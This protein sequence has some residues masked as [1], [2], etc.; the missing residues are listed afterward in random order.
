MLYYNVLRDNPGNKRYED[1]ETTHYK[2][3]YRWG[4]LI[5]AQGFVPTRPPL[6]ARQRLTRPFYA[7]WSLGAP[8]YGTKKICPYVR[9][10][11]DGA[12]RYSLD[13]NCRWSA[14]ATKRG[15]EMLLN[16]LDASEIAMNS[17]GLSVDDE[18]VGERMY[19]KHSKDSVH[20]WPDEYYSNPAFCWA[21]IKWKTR[22]RYP[23]IY[24]LLSR[25][26]ATGLIPIGANYRVVLLGG[27]PG[28]GAAAVR[29]HWG[30]DGTIIN[31]DGSEMLGIRSPCYGA[32]FEHVQFEDEAAIER[33]CKGAD[34]I[35]SSFSIAYFSKRAP[36]MERLLRSTGAA[37]V[38]NCSG[39]K[40]MWEDFS[41]MGGIKAT[42]LL[43]ASDRRQYLVTKE[44]APRESTREP[45]LEFP[46]VPYVEKPRR[47][48]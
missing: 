40:S 46:G 6:R 10:Q 41:N 28:F 35:I 12:S 20:T 11:P 37:L 22:Q 1:L 36:F 24:N 2:S 44:G 33:H 31:L 47:K 30:S 23:E 26:R 27:G 16:V 39:A 21:Y 17:F 25:S 19:S 13:A 42:P 3:M 8:R 29:D 48:K 4:R 15:T 45:V 38:V 32:I 5:G 14:M 18:A 7:V 34:L 9:R 43:G